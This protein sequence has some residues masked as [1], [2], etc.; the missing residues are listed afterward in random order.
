MFPIG[1]R[2]PPVSPLPEPDKTLPYFEHIRSE[3]TRMLDYYARNVTLVDQLCSDR[4]ALLKYEY[5]Y[6]ER[7][8]R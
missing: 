6:D 1:C 5:G 3:A 7:L 2:K 8:L 4:K